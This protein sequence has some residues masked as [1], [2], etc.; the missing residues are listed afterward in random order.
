MKL[1]FLSFIAISFCFVACNKDNSD[2]NTEEVRYLDDSIY[3]Y[4]FSANKDSSIIGRQYF[5]YDPKGNIINEKFYIDRNKP[6]RIASQTENEYNEFGNLTKRVFSNWDSITNKWVVNN[7][8]IYS[9]I[10]GYKLIKEELTYYGYGD[11]RISSKSK[12]E[13]SLNDKGFR[14]SAI[15]YQWDIS[16]SKWNS[17]TRFEFIT[18]DDGNII[19]SKTYHIDNYSDEET[20]YER[21]IS[22]YNSDGELL[23]RETYNYESPEN[24]HW[25]IKNINEYDANG[26][27]LSSTTSYYNFP[28]NTTNSYKFIFVY[29]SAGKEI[30]S[31][32][33]SDERN[34]GTFQIFDK[35]YIYYNSDGAATYSVS[36]EN[37]RKQASRIYY[38]SKHRVTIKDNS[39]SKLKSVAFFPHKSEFSPMLLPN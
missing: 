7:N 30:Y 9:Y 29:D 16:Y 24:S 13:Y 20:L 1:L 5:V 21:E 11:N 25:V 17:E 12:T 39:K 22:T 28:S 4:E 3:S 38:Q 27:L 8:K 19:D 10:N 31:E 2:N 6:F 37:N 26:N 33:S 18:D 14:A 23:S 34:E 15:L 36:Y 35:E 32:A